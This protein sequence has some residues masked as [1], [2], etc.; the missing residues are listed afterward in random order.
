[1][2]EQPLQTQDEVAEEDETLIGF[3]CEE[4][5]WAGTQPRIITETEESG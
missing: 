5:V 2:P 3:G 4:D 1:M